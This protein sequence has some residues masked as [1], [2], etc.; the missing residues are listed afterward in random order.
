MGDHGRYIP[1]KENAYLEVFV[2]PMNYET[3]KETID[4]EYDFELKHVKERGEEVETL[5]KTGARLNRV[6]ATRLNLRYVDTKTGVRMLT[7]VIICVPMDKEHKGFVYKIYLVTPESSYNDDR[8][9][10]SRVL[11][12][13]RFTTI[14]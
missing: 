14:P 9:L 5:S 7:D 1:I 13:W 4:D 8:V 2:G 11:Q 10:L 3:R 6:T 12:N